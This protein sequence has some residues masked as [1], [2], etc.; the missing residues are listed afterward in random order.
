M[1][2]CEKMMYPALDTWADVVLLCLAYKGK[3]RKGKKNLQLS[4]CIACK[5]QAF[6]QAAH[7]LPKLCGT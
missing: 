2:R 1:D 4:N 3:I 5:M 7:H 6:T